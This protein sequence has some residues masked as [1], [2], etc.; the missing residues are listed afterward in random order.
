MNNI[1]DDVAAD[2]ARLEYRKAL[3]EA[4]ER[5]SSSFL[6]FCQYVWPEMLVGE[7]HKQIAEK[8]DRVV[9]AKGLLLPCP[10]GT[11]SHS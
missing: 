8:F 10:R 4:Q 5:A 9:N 7:H 11:V 2:L 3:L 1:P 6:D